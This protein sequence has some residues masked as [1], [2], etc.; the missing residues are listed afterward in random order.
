MPTYLQVVSFRTGSPPADRRGTPRRLESPMRCPY[1]PATQQRKSNETQRQ[2]SI[3]QQGRA[4]VLL[5]PIRA[6]RN[7]SAS[8]ASDGPSRNAKLQPC[9]PTFRWCHSEPVR[10]RRTGEEPYVDLNY[11]CRVRTYR[12]LSKGKATRH[13]VSDPFREKGRARVYSC[14]LGRREIKARAQRATGPQGMQ[15]FSHA[16]LPS[17]GVI[18]NRS[19]AG[20]PERNLTSA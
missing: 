17:G 10:R 2:R 3:S 14:Q 11:Q 5:V 4:R 15:S 16:H 8:A 6:Q 7:Q 1:V 19:A 9:P 13:K 18:P 20:G 12:R